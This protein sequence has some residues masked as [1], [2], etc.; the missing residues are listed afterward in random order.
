MIWGAVLY[1]AS[2]PSDFSSVL[3]KSAFQNMNSKRKAETWKKNRRQLVSGPADLDPGASF[4]G[5][6][7]WGPFWVQLCLAR[8]PRVTKGQR[9]HTVHPLL[10]VKVKDQT[11]VGVGRAAVCFVKEDF[12]KARSLVEWG[13]GGS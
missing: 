1:F 9:G 4:P 6:A 2:L 10:P 3:L 8:G 7:G 11:R 13:V 5:G 12:R